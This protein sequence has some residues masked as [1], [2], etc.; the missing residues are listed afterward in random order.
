MELKQNLV[1]RK[2]KKC[3]ARSQ[4][5]LGDDYSV[6]DG[7]PDIAS[8]L[9][10]KSELRVDDVHTEKGKIKIRGALKVYVL[11]LAQRSSELVNFLEMEFPFDE[12][13][14]MEAAASGDNL[15]IDW[16]IEELRVTIIHPGKI[17]VRALIT[18]FGEIMA[19]ENYLPTEMIADAQNIFTQSANFIMAEPVIERRDSYRIRDEIGLPANKPNMQKLIWKDLQLRGLEL[20]IQEGRI[21]VKG[22]MLMFAVY[23]SED[24]H[25]MVQWM[26][27]AVPFH[28]T[29]DVTGLTPEM[30]G[31]FET[32][33]SHQD[34]EMKPDYDG[35]MRMF[36]LEMLI[37]I[38][39]HVF[40]EKNC[41]YLMDAYST[42][43]KLNL[44]EEEICYEKLRMCNHT[45]CRLSEKEN[46]SDERK[47]LQ[48]LGHH[49][50]LTNKR[51]LVTEQGILCE[52]SLEVQVLYVT[53]SDSQPFGNITIFMSYSQLIEIPE[54][55]KEDRWNVREN[56]DQ[57]MITMSDSHQMEVRAT[58]SIVSC[59]MEQLS[60]KNIRE[61]SMEEYDMEEYKMRPGMTIHFVQPGE[62]LWQLAKENRST[63]EEIKNVN[64]MASE[65][66]IPGQKLLL[67]KACKYGQQPI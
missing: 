12:I 11:Y 27:Q 24:E 46:I 20:Q 50:K 42:E 51:C 52:G 49:A 13:L 22:E 41:T 6:P 61:I 32:E 67:L 10:K 59:V 16:N 30:I 25:A 14:Y 34:I 57:I 15:K 65:E 21:G 48:I 38:H 45:K 1:H 4:I 35:E 23:Q 44:Q 2:Y 55:S 60:L 53:A 5:T 3:E 18:L 33:I 40:E 19:A 54:M 36:Q 17:S 62:T 63:V 47:I 31:F 29:L 28:G 37:E 56:I 43:C 58:L 8:V 7:K 39:M 66:V 26:E 9:Q 64:E